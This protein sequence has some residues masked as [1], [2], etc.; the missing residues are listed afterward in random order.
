[1]PS[2]ILLVPF[3]PLREGLTP[4]SLAPLMLTEAVLKAP[5]SMGEG[6]RAQGQPLLCCRAV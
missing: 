6:H 4:V 2:R 3:F 1:M 5:G